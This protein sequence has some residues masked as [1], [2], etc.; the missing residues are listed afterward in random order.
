MSRLDKLALLD[1]PSLPPQAFQTAGRGRLTTLWGGGTPDTSKQQEAA[2][3]TAEL[4]QEQLDWAKEIYAETA[5]DREE[6]KRRA[7]ELSDLQMEQMRRAA[8]QSEKLQARYDAMYLPVERSIIADA[9]SYDTD[10]RKAAEAGRAVA[11]VE[12]AFA[13]TRGQ[14]QRAMARMGVNPSDGRQAAM[15]SQMD[16]QQALARATAANN[17]RRN[18][19]TQGW[20]RRMDAAGLG[21]GVVSGQATQAGMAANLGNSAL[22]ASNAALGAGQSGAGIMQGGYQGAISGNTAAGNMWGNIANQQAAASQAESAN[23]AAGA[24]AVATVAGVII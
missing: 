20:A 15:S 16:A 14:S 23:M 12:Q 4:S 21:R 5:P 9:A 3:L 10:A 17:A 8:D 1:V 2:M 11:D 19:E 7:N 18:V 6:A 13:N 24:G 22:N